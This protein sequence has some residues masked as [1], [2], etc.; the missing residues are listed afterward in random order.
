MSDIQIARLR[1]VKKEL[2]EIVSS[3]EIDLK[4]IRDESK[5]IKIV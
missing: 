5:K 2:D 3:K 4:E 1:T